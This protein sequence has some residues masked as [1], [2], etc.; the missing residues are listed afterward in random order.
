MGGE[1]GVS[2]AF[3][4][5]FRRDALS[6]AYAFTYTRAAEPFTTRDPDP[7]D[8]PPQLPER[9]RFATL[10][11]GW[12]H[13]DA[14]R[15]LYDISPSNGRTM[16]A[17]AALSEPALGSQYRVLTLA[18]SLTQYVPL[19]AHHVLA[20]RYAAGVSLGDGEH[21]GVFQ[22]GGFPQVSLV[23]GLADPVILGGQALRGYAAGDRAGS[24]FHL[25]QLEY[26]FPIVR[27]NRG[28]L[29]L[30]VYL[31]RLWATVFA[32]AGDAFS[33]AIDLARF[34]V[35]VGAE[36]HLD[37]TLFYILPL[38]LRLGYGRGLAEGGL[39]QF[40]GHLGVPF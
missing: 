1:V 37:F 12:S 40:Y 10:R 9:G 2:Y 5:A 15:Y 7:N 18:T 24:Q 13:S 4:R 29:T 11:F 33:S 38:S 28:V 3:P 6:L 16:G 8:A 32:D 20:L 26:R 30:P 17:S 14:E 21:L 34:R 35:G 27:L 19:W 22:L 31:N 39:D 23:E 25:V 36:L